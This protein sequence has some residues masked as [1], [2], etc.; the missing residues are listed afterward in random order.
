ML[1][2]LLLIVQDVIVLVLALSATLLS[3]SLIGG[4]SLEFDRYSVFTHTILF[5]PVICISIFFFVVYG[6]YD[7]HVLYKRRRLVQHILMASAGVLV[8][9]IVWFYLFPLQLDLRPKVI[10]ILY[11]V[12]GAIGVSLV[13]WRYFLLRRKLDTNSFG[14]VSLG[15]GSRLKELHQY[16]A[17][18]PYTG[19]RATELIDPKMYTTESD[20]D[21]LQ[22]RLSK[23]KIQ[24]LVIDTKDENA[25]QIARK[26]YSLVFSGVKFVSYQDMYERIFDKEDLEYIDERWFMA[27]ITGKTDY[28][29]TILKRIMDLCIALPLFILSIVIYPFV[30]IAIKLEDRGP[31][32]ARMDRIGQNNKIINIVKFRSM[33]DVD[34]GTWVLK[35]GRGAEDKKNEGR[36]VRVTKVGR[37]IRKTRIDELPQLW[38]VVKGDLSLIGPRP[39]M[40]KMVEFYEKEIPFYSVRHTIRPGLSGWAQIHHEVPPHSVDGTKEKLSYDLYYLKHRSIFLDLLIA[41]RTMQTVLSAVGL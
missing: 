32:F 19:F 5:I 22:D 10:L 15:G 41:L 38:N 29:Y 35:E 27:H 17:S 25:E 11:V 4:S 7:R 2:S 33:R 23:M 39:E 34:D 18:A 21:A 16:I 31:L 30:Y 36:Q 26:M 37:F 6:L 12:Y 14:L 24:Y 20:M 13:R 8:L 9:G 3:R 1:K 28:I 40:P